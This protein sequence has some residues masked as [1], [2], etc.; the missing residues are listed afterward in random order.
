MSPS[1]SSR[2]LTAAARAGSR[3]ASW[4]CRSASAAAAP[5]WNA[6]ASWISKSSVTRVSLTPRP[7]STGTSARKRSSCWARR[8]DSS[9]VS[10]AAVKLSSPAE[11]ASRAARYAATSP[12]AAAAASVV[13]LLPERVRGRLA[14]GPRRSA[15]PG[16]ASRRRPAPPTPRGG[17]AGCAQRPRRRRRAGRAGGPGRRRAGPCSPPGRR[18]PARSAPRSRLRTASVASAPGR[19]RRVAVRNSRSSSQAR[20][21]RTSPARTASSVT[22]IAPRN[23]GALQRRRARRR[24]R[25]RPRPPGRRPRRPPGAPRAACGGPR[26]RQRAR[27]RDARAQLAARSPRRPLRGAA[28]GGP[29]AE[30][31]LG[32][33]VE[34]APAQRLGR[35][36]RRRPSPAAA[37]GEAAA[38]RPATAMTIRTAARRIIRLRLE[39]DVQRPAAWETWPAIASARV[40]ASA[41]S[42]SAWSAVNFLPPASSSRRRSAN[43]VS[44]VEVLLGLRRLR[45]VDLGDARLHARVDRLQA[46]E[47]VGDVLQARSGDERLL[48]RLGARDEARVLPGVEVLRHRRRH[49]DERR[50][51]VLRRRRPLARGG[52]ELLASSSRTRARR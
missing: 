26:R 16:S 12:A 22:A 25:A 6:T 20:A 24:A 17:S 37:A 39:L 49:H 13:E 35:L 7:Y 32:L 5:V 23:S 2:S 34:Q 21:V 4:S 38:S 42:V 18:R 8:A 40:C 11:T 33:R 50:E 36:P 30:D 46:A 27:R 29:V 51:R 19:V 14:R 1:S 41:P 9:A 15:A 45:V 47:D 28:R 48:L 10:G 31:Q 44:S 43:A 52:V 3:L